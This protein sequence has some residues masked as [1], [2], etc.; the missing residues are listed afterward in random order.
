MRWVVKIETN[1]FNSFDCLLFQ[2]FN[3]KSLFAALHLDINSLKFGLLHLTGQ[4]NSQKGRAA[5]VKDGTIPETK[6]LETIS[7]LIVT[8]LFTSAIY[9]FL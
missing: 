9:E 7:G 1:V 8:K 5:K 4:S 6:F 3:N 2:L